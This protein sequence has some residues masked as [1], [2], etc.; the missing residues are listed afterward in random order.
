[1]KLNPGDTIVVPD[2]TLR[3]T[4]LRGLLDWTQIFSQLAIGA[5]AVE[6]LK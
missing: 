4:A 3:P 6:V 1:M 5:A 2:K